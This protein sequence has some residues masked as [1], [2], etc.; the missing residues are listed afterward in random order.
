M[1]VYFEDALINNFL[2]ISLVLFLGVFVLK[3]KVSKLKLIGVTF[4]C[5]ILNVFSESF[6]GDFKIF[7]LTKIIII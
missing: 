1:E 7:V 4:L 5:V 6:M 3:I 2:L